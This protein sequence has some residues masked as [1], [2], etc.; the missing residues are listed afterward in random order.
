MSHWPYRL[1]EPREP[2][3]RPSGIRQ[4]FF[5]T[6][7]RTRDWLSLVLLF[8]NKFG[9]SYCLVN[10]TER[11]WYRKFRVRTHRH[12]CIIFFGWG[13]LEKVVVLIKIDSYQFMKIR[14]PFKVSLSA[15]I[16]KW[17]SYTKG[18][19]PK[20]MLHDEDLA[21]KTTKLGQFVNEMWHLGTSRAMARFL[22]QVGWK[23][24]VSESHKSLLFNGRAKAD[25]V[26]PRS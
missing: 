21:E 16:S 24:W 7:K 6:S 9:Q 23:L 20:E 19:L 1:A 10:S 13:N 4:G 25:Y 12:G 8:L 14:H 26:E 5:T 17:N 3:F 22:Q 11:G 18:R 15:P 2:L